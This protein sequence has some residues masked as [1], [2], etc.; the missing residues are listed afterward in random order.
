MIILDV[1]QDD[2][3]ELNY[4]RFYHPDPIV[5]KRCETVYLNAKKLKTGQIRELTGFDCKTIRAH[6]HLYQNGGIEALKHRKPYR[7]K[8][9][10]DQHRQT[11]EQ[12]FQVRPPASIKEAGERIFK[13]TGIRRSDTR[14]EVFVKRLGMKFLVFH[15][16]VRPNVQWKKTSQRPRGLQR[17][18]EKIGDGG[19]RFVHQFDFGLRDAEVVAEDPCQ[20]SHQDRAGQRGLPAVRV[21]PE[22]GEGTQHHIVVFASLFTELKFDRTVVEVREKAITQ[23]LLL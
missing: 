1:P 13:R 19:E 20:R 12:E 3:D 16:N 22:F 7:P 18:H 9:E 2:L 15:T 10:L 8:G 11:I 14:V 6:L 21:S 5:M 23:Q 17:D 4:L